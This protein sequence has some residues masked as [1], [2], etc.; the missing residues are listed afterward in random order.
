MGSPP[1][2]G[3]PRVFAA[4]YEKAKLIDP[5][6]AAAYV[7]HLHVGDP[8]ADALMADLARFSEDEQHPLLRA[9]V[10]QNDEALRGTPQSFRDFA[11]EIGTLPAW[12][13]RKVA[14]HGCRVFLAHSD[15]FLAGFA[16]GAIVEGF[17]TMISKSF[18]LTGRM[19]DDGVRRLKQNLRHL[20]DMFLPRGIE[21]LGDGWRLTIRIRLVHARVRSLLK[22][23]DE[24]DY[25][26]WGMPISAAHTALATAAFSSR[27][28]QFAE[29]LGASLDHDDREAFMSVW[30]CAAHQ[31]GVPAPMLF[32]SQADGLHL[33]RVAT[34]CE[35]PPDLDAVALAH[36]IVNSAPVVV[37]VTDPKARA[38]FA[39]YV[40]RVSR[41]LVGDETADRLRFPPRHAMPVLPWLRWRDRV[42]RGFTRFFPGMDSARKRESFT[43][44]LRL[45]DLGESRVS[46]NL[47]DHVRS[48]ESS[49]W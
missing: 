20:L 37:G 17:S 43:N 42:W 25:D 14:R 10:E 48:D 7:A 47:P 39:R 45:A 24:W 44:I 4:G 9:I 13:D 18:A 5:G 15:E 36:C 38:A 34:T 49:R 27:L 16:G 29:K 26:A 30:S 19:L 21:P 8:A 35:P 46:Y 28:L 33:L 1:P 32:H 22:S 41:E 6:L 12:Y 23:S 3:I 2:R 11:H 31:M 40:Y